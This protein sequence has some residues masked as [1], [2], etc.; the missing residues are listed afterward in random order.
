MVNSITLVLTH[1]PL[2]VMQEI[3]RRTRDRSN[4][5]QAGTT[6]GWLEIFQ[7]SNESLEKVR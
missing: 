1:L 2:H 3:M 7:K 6:A 5:L 4:A